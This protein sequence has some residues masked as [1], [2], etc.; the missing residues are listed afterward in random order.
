MDEDI[1]DLLSGTEA[2]PFREATLEASTPAPGPAR[3]PSGGDLPS[4]AGN[5]GR[6]DIS[7]GDLLT[8]PDCPDEG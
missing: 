8:P 6:R 3:R 5:R 1:G 2:A 7:A 4:G